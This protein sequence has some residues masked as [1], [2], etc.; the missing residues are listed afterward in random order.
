VEGASIRRG[1]IIAAAAA[2]TLVAIAGAFFFYAA[3]NLDAIV[4]TNRGRLQRYV[5]ATLGRQIVVDRIRAHLGWGISVELE[6]LKIADDPAFSQRPF[7]TTNQVSCRVDFLA[8][9]AGEV[10]ISKLIFAQPEIW[11]RRGMRGEL[12]ISTF[13]N[14]AGSKPGGGV[15]QVT[16]A[17]LNELRI[18]SLRIDRGRLYF[19]QARQNGPIAMTQVDLALDNFSARAPFDVGLKLALPASAKQNLELSGQAGPLLRNGVFDYGR[20]PLDLELKADSIEWAASA[21]A[22]A[23]A[24]L[25]VA[26]PL[27]IDGSFSFASRITGSIGEFSFNATADLTGV[28]VAQARLWEKAAG[29]VMNISASGKRANGTIAVSAGKLRL[30]AM[31]VEASSVTFD[32]AG[33][34]ASVLVSSNEFD[35][36]PMGA[37]VLPLRGFGAK[38][39]ASFKGTA[40]ID[41]GAANADLTL[42]L[43]GVSANVAPISPPE[44]R[45][46]K[47]NVIIA[48]TR[49]STQ[50]LSFAA[51]SSRGTLSAELDSISPLQATY[52]LNMDLVRPGQ[53]IEGLDQ[54]N[55]LQNMTDVGHVRG[56]PATP[57][58]DG[59]LRSSSGTISGIGYTNLIADQSYDGKTVTA[60]QVQMDAL[61]GT[62]GISGTVSTGPKPRFDLALSPHN[63]DVQRL[64]QAEQLSAASWVRGA[65]SGKFR[66]AGSGTSEGTLAGGG[67]L[68]LFQG[69]LIGV[70]IVAVALNKVAG[71]PGVSHL[72]SDV[73]RTSNQRLFGDPD[74]ELDQAGMTFTMSGGRVTTHD[75]T[76]QSRDYGITADG[77]FDLRKRLNMTAEIMLVRGLDVAIPVVVA[78]ELPV[79]IVLP[80][81]PRL[82]ERIA[83]GALAVPGKIIRGG[84]K[85]LGTLFGGSK[86]AG[87]SGSGPGSSGISSPLKNL[88]P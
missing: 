5:G 34:S 43:D 71:S 23:T 44:I 66:V 53:F 61:G 16:A 59:N 58:I 42:K 38:G 14:G 48:G 17:Q 76:I 39:R 52:S 31:E 85:G 22:L 3:R 20:V 75:L 77:W 29:T 87:G 83:M 86:S 13:G 18:T 47:G 19:E 49:V 73:F 7:L 55:I 9:L 30:A 57:T 56:D 26:M 88:L 15:D 79:P 6:N 35:L 63:V 64:F 4:A 37:M 78:G 80:N 45:E 54:S 12:N 27:S 65:V 82:A 8:L 67:T 60:R 70:N 50:G 24:D 81:I 74:T 46:V 21:A 1:L 72:I 41:H 62:L 28:R 2:M 51:G 32:P 84:V 33:P 40:R 69:K 10:R 36:A 68:E 25:P 11:L